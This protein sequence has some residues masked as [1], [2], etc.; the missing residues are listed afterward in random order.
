MPF[1]HIAAVLALLALVTGCSS[2]VVPSPPRH[3]SRPPAV[4]PTSEE[5]RRLVLP[6]DAYALSGPDVHTIESAEDVLIRDCMRAKGKA[7]R[8]L[9]QPSTVDPD[10]PQR[11]R[12]GVIEP[13]VARRFGYHLPP[14]PPETAR[15]DE[16][17]RARE[18][19]PRAAQLA[20]YGKDGVGGCWKKA[21]VHLLR[22][23]PKG[24]TAQFNRRIRDEFTAS[25]QHRAVRSVVRSWSACMKGN[26]Y[27]YPDPLAAAGDDRWAKSPRPSR[28]EIAV[29]EADVR[30]KQETRLVSVWGKAETRIQHDVVRS[31]AAEFRKLAT[32][33][34]SWL[35]AA[36]RVIRGGA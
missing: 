22:G 20:A 18:K 23:V 7:W 21:H 33:K 14:A 5:V 36:R 35:K 34:S 11:R 1:R 15:R 32:Q 31:H 26:G 27:R 9:P 3:T 24:S 4:P 17:W 6:F 12:Y 29:A 16:I 2:G 13:D 10:P 25:Q 30:C 19:M 28:Q 8:A